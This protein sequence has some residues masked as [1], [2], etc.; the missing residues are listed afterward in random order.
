MQYSALNVTSSYFAFFPKQA[1]SLSPTHLQKISHELTECNLVVISVFLRI[2]MWWPRRL[3]SRC[4][5]TVTLVIRVPIGPDWRQNLVSIVQVL[6]PDPVHRF[7]QPR[8][9]RR[10]LA[11]GDLCVVSAR[12]LVKLLVQFALDFPEQ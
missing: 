7:S 10:K 5:M 4:G 11:Y 12:A 2:S 1:L 3:L 6:L 9:L 8:W